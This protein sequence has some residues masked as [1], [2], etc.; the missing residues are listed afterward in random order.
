MD[1]FDD[2]ATCIK[3]IERFAFDTEISPSNGSSYTVAKA[4]PLADSRITR[5]NDDYNAAM[6]FPDQPLNLG[7]L[8]EISI[9]YSDH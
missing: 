8:V 3:G 4:N 6:S 1:V 5:T 2:D 7:Y 9:M